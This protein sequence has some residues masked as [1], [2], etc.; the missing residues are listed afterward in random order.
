MSKA[1]GKSGKIRFGN[2]VDK[3]SQQKP[4]STWLTI[5]TGNKLIFFQ[6]IALERRSENQNL[7]EQFCC[8][9]VKTFFFPFGCAGGMR[10]FKG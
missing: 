10:K 7:L 2:M 8:R 1:A 9:I 6:E 3:L 5:K 4:N